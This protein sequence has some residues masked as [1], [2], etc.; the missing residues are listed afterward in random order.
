MEEGDKKISIL[1]DGGL[2]DR[3][4]PALRAP[5]VQHMSS[6]PL[7]K[8]DNT[9]LSVV[10]GTAAR[11]PGVSSI[12]GS[13]P[14]TCHGIIPAGN[15]ESAAILFRG[16]EQRACYDF[17]TLRSD[18]SSSVFGA[19]ITTFMTR[20][21]GG[22]S[23]GHQW[24]GHAPCIQVDD[25][26]GRV[27]R[28]AV[29]ESRDASGDHE[30]YVSI[31]EQDGTIV[32]SARFTSTITAT[33]ARWFTLTSHGADVMVLWY[34]RT[35][36]GTAG[37]KCRKLTWNHSTGALSIAAETSVVTPA[38]A[39]VWY[40]VKRLD[41][42]HAVIVTGHPSTA[43]N[44]RVIKYQVHTL[45]SAATFDHAGSGTAFEH[46]VAVETVSGNLRVAVAISSTT[47]VNLVVYLLDSSLA[48]VWGPITQAVSTALN[49]IAAGFVQLSNITAS[50]V[51]AYER[52]TGSISSGSALEFQLFYLT[53][54]AGALTGQ[55]IRHWKRLVSKGCQ[56]KWSATEFA[57]A[58]LFHTAFT[59]VSTTP[60][61]AD[62]V[63]DPAIELWMG[64]RQSSDDTMPVARLGCVRGSV[65]AFDG[66]YVTDRPSSSGCAAYGTRLFLDYRTSNNRLDAV[67][68]LPEY[69]VNTASVEFSPEQL[70]M[71]TD[72]DGVAYVA[73]GM[74]VSWDGC[75]LFE[76]GAPLSR[77]HIAV[78]TTG[79]SGTAYPSGSYAFCAVYVWKD[80]AGNMHRSRLSN[81]VL[82]TGNGANS[83]RLRAPAPYGF[84]R[85]SR[86]QSTIVATEA[87]C[88][89]VNTPDFHKLTRGFAP[90]YGA[91]DSIDNV[92]IPLASDPI[93]YSTGEFAQELTPQPPPPLRDVAIVGARMWGIDAEYPYRLPY[94]KLRVAG[95]GYEF[96]PA[97]EVIIPSSGG[98]AQRVFEVAGTVVVL[99]E[100]AVWQFSGFGPDNT[101]Q[102]GSFSPPIKLSDYGCSNP[103]AAA[104][105]PGGLV[106][107]S[108]DRWYVLQRGAL[109]QDQNVSVGMTVTHSLTFRDQDE[110]AFYGTQTSFDPGDTFGPAI[111]KVYNYVTGRWTRW[112]ALAF[113]HLASSPNESRRHYAF[114]NG[115]L[116]KIDADALADS[117][118]MVFEIDL[119]NLA[120]DFQ[121]HVL[122]RDVVFYGQRLGA[123]GVTIEIFPD[124]GT[125]ATTSRPY[126]D[127]EITGFMTAAGSAPWYV[128]RVEPKDQDMRAARVRITL[129]VSGTGEGGR[130]LSLTLYFKPYKTLREEAF[131][132]GSL[133]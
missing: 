32:R 11:A 37:L 71:A 12:A 56:V 39:N 129:T 61:D 10:R 83:P 5:V 60:A 30:L 24:T 131:V 85:K 45:S 4:P 107:Q 22:G 79:G 89:P 96:H 94:S 66:S 106:W 25:A 72:R 65:A 110:I 75:E 7:A 2:A 36:G 84:T 34:V 127:G 111:A 100:R 119:T 54:A 14:T 109:E 27:W 80:A 88:T 6:P 21:L 122:L 64:G 73:G 116:Y 115:T 58:F 87:Y 98:E 50:V 130:P 102:G 1:L 108:G 67:S 125:T 114:H 120:G 92:P 126:T 76:M 19:Q 118:S 117:A 41:D 9:R 82:F 104:A 62:Y 8:S 103:H 59:A 28:I 78:L 105:F 18:L 52:G 97:L 47:S 48:T 26:N 112:N 63:D 35:A 128:L 51:V 42:N 99:A 77:P 95:V 133:K 33:V 49:R 86:Y 69:N 121:D 123:H 31:R 40:D 23:N 20:V 101:G 68:G 43:A 38:S 132:A 53:V 81:V 29:P 93:L 13:L 124:H 55:T 3:R 113:T 44:T 90:S 57:P 70:F 17:G 91:L 15:G 74:P 16:A 46:A